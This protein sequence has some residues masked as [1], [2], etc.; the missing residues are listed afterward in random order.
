M[1][2]WYISLICSLA[3]TTKKGAEPVK[4][5][6][7]VNLVEIYQKREEGS[8]GELRPPPTKPKMKFIAISSI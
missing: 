2:I 1:H 7:G 3:S 5:R 8:G 4:Q 6:G